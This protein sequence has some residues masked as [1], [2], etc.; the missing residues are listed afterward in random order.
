[1][2]GIGKVMVR[3][4]C[5]FSKFVKCYREEIFSVSQEIITRILT[6]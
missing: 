5:L 3:R 4:M 6:T 2:G 1:M